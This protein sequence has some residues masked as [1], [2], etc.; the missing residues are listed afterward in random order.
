LEKIVN[1]ALSKKI[2]DRYMTA[3]DF[4]QD[5]NTLPII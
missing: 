1:K 4:L 3:D 5:W 2:E